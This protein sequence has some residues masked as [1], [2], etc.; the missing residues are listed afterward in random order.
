MTERRPL[1]N[2]VLFVLGLAVLLN[3]IDRGNLATAAPLLQ[4]E[5]SLSA[6][7]MG[8]LFSSFFWTYAPRSCWQ[9]GWYIAS[10]YESFWPRA[11]RSG[12]RP[13]P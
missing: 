10:T 5:L 7:Q 11:W 9:S 8:L 13:P 3:Y 1:S 12:L 6:T 4:E 2:G